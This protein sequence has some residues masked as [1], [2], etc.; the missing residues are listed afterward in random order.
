[1][2]KFNLKQ[3]K[4]AAQ[5]MIDLLELSEHGE[6]IVFEDDVDQEEVERVINL[7]IPL[8]EIGQNTD[9]NGKV[10]PADKF[11]KETQEVLDGMEAYQDVVKAFKAKSKKAA[12]KPAAKK[13]AK[14]VEPEEDPEETTEV[15]AEEDEHITELREEIEDADKLSELKEIANTNKEFKSLLNTL[16]KFTK[17]DPLREAMNELLDKVAEKTEEDPEEKKPAKKAA[18]VAKKLV[19][20]EDVEEKKPAAKKPAVEKK[21][22]LAKKEPKSSYTRID[23]VCDAL[24]TRKPK[25][26]EAWIAASNEEYVENGG[27]ENDKES[28]TMIKYAQKVLSHFDVDCPTA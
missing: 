27:S 15:P 25:T 14:E 8:I 20:E 21:A 18:P 3:L 16:T 23:A 5:E 1:M 11:S 24:K 22:A 17:P 10:I 9:D 13:P 6:V 19:V 7:A 28:L 2:A 12:A 26:V 4:K